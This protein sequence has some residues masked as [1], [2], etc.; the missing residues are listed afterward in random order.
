AVGLF[1]NTLPLRVTIDGR[2]VEDGLRQTH[3]R[4]GELLVHEHASLVFAQRCSG[5]PSP[6]P[7]FTT[8][9][10]YRQGRAAP[11]RERTT[12]AFEGITSL[13]GE[14][15]TNY[16]LAISI[17]DLGEGV[18]IGVQASAGVDPQRICGLM[19]QALDELVKALHESP[20]R[21]LRLIDVLPEAERAQ[22]VE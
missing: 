9:L 4:L 16:P 18:G 2:S 20:R 11:G 19:H 17:D 7:L 13:Y 22:V 12:R 10:N 8:L 5:V 21:A 6:A 14:E 3:E 1:A 15:R